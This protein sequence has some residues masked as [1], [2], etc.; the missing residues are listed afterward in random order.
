MLIM[1]IR[2]W[3]ISAIAWI[4]AMLM[5]CTSSAQPESEP[6]LDQHA[7]LMSPAPRTKTGLFPDEHAE[8]VHR[9]HDPREE[10][11]SREDWPTDD[12][13]QPLRGCDVPWDFVPLPRK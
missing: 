12:F 10:D 3:A 13:G 5:T 4:F 6:A 7:R 8:A 9:Q 1:P 2:R 11:N